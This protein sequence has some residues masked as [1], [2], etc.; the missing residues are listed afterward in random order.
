MAQI[1]NLKLG[2]GLGLEWKQ[3]DFVSLLA[4][5]TFKNVIYLG[6]D[7]GLYTAGGLKLCFEYLLSQWWLLSECCHIGDCVHLVDMPE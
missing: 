2:V 4:T 3:Q 7:L 1:L 6:L 5:T